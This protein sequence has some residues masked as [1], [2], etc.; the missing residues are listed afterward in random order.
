MKKNVVV[1]GYPKSGNTWCTRLVAQVLQAPVVGFFG[2]DNKK[3]LAEEGADRVSDFAVYKAHH[4]YARLNQSDVEHK[5]I[6]VVRDPR[7]VA[8]SGAHYFPTEEFNTANKTDV[9]AFEAMVRTI[10]EGGVYPGCRKPWA[11]LVRPYLNNEVFR[12]RYEDLLEN[13][14]GE[15][16]RILAY[17]GVT[18]SESEIAEAIEAQ[19]FDKA[20]SKF[21]GAKAKKNEKLMR[22]GK[23]GQHEVH[24]SAEQIER[25]N[26]ACAREMKQLKYL[27]PK[28]TK[29][30]SAS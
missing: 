17:L 28:A 3:E 23:S 30:V 22:E 24:L 29:K 16:G 1:V 19:S 13:P 11:K 27:S 26:T 2:A 21:V 4:A 6:Y 14:E 5:A 7:D 20:R 25:I 9:D 15:V 12:V 18:R 10:C 8:V